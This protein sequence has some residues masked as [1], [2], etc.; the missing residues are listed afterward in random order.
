MP[1]K[2][3]RATWTPVTIGVHADISTDTGAHPPA[4]REAFAQIDRHVEI[5]TDGLSACGRR[6]LEGLG[7]AEARRLCR[8]ALVGTGMARVVFE[9]PSAYA[10]G[11]LSVFNGG[12]RG[13]ETRLLVHAIAAPGQIAV[14][15]VTISEVQSSSRYTHAATVRIPQIGEGRGSLASVDLSLGRRYSV[16]SKSRSFLSARCTDGWLLAL[17]PK[18]LFRN[19]VPTPGVPATTVLKGRSATPCTV[20]PP[21]P[22]P[23]R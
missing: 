6:K 18:I 2:L 1:A 3:P 15:S 10:D 20:V 11:P 5:E 8:A 19:E 12:T 9:S 7:F 4:L 23:R 21:A 13:G 17:V 16:A 22:A 14:G